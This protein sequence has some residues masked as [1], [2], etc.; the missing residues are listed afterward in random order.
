MNSGE[1]D[2]VIAKLENHGH[3]YEKAGALWF[4]STDFGDDKDRVVRR[5]NGRQPTLQA[6]SPILPTNYHAV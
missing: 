3:L 4:K 5:E 1:I 6:I 2:M